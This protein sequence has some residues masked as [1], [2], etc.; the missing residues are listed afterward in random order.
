M[1]CF[2]LA[3]SLGG[4]EDIDEMMQGNAIV[5]LDLLLQIVS[6][7]DNQTNKYAAWENQIYDLQNPQEFDNKIEALEKALDSNSEAF[8]YFKLAKICKEYPYYDNYII[9]SEIIKEAMY[10]KSNQYIDK[11][12]LL[13]PNAEY[14][15]FRILLE[16]ENYSNF[17]DIKALN[18]LEK[19]RDQGGTDYNYYYYSNEVAKNTDN[20]NLMILSTE[21]LFAIENNTWHLANLAVNYIQKEQYEKAINLYNRCIDAENDYSN[22]YEYH[23]SI[24]SILYKQNKPEQAEAIF[25]N[26]LQQ[27]HN[28]FEVYK[29][30]AEALLQLGIQEKENKVIKLYLEAEKAFD[31]QTNNYQKYS[32]YYNLF[33]LYNKDRQ[34]EKALEAISNT[35]LYDNHDYIKLEKIK[36]LQKMGKTQEAETEKLTLGEP[37]DDFQSISTSN[38]DDFWS[39]EVDVLNN[40]FE[41]FE[42]K[43]EQLKQDLIEI[44]NNANKN[45]L[46]A[47]VYENYP[48]YSLPDEGKSIEKEY[49]KNALE[50]F[51]LAINQEQKASFYL[52]RAHF[53]YHYGYYIQE[54][55]SYDFYDTITSDYTSFLN[56]TQG[57]KYEGYEG[58]MRVYQFKDNYTEAVYYGNLA[59]EARPENT[60]LL[61]NIGSDNK[62]ANQFADALN[63]YNELLLTEPESSNAIYAQCGIAEIYI[64]KN[65]PQRA[66]LLFEKILKNKTTTEDQTEALL[67]F[68]NSFG[69]NGFYIEAVN[70]CRQAVSIIQ[71]DPPNEYSLASALFSLATYQEYL[72]L[73]E[74]IVTMRKLCELSRECYY[75][76]Y[77]GDLY[78]KKNNTTEAKNCF[79]QALIIDS[80]S[81]YAKQ[82]LD[83]LNNKKSFFDKIFKR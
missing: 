42:I 5:Q 12:I 83:E 37:Y 23:K 11:A 73:D 78:T 67:Q 50:N 22:Q 81:E 35:L 10:T 43:I 44:P 16:L 31:E 74:A 51:N 75:F 70:Y 55:D 49:R 24:A 56:L 57:D 46:L 54:N 3:L 77:L 19:Y 18:D 61:L 27:K 65:E 30:Q 28:A 33:E 63:A 47:K 2:K 40:E 66:V 79:K 72:N 64:F 80:E 36:L 21:Q 60:Y 9:D 26:A 6:E 45:F 68:G 71:K 15:L 59:Y 17:N 29:D 48:F 25:N 82:Q 62:K 69:N 34:Y 39:F 58:L 13:E 41:A 38:Q 7:G 52:A 20:E 8:E 76:T 32:L 4:S 14:Y 1:Y 53:L